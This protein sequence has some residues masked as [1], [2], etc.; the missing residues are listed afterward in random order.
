MILFSC[1]PRVSRHGMV[2]KKESYK[3]LYKKE[4]TKS[5][6]TEIFGSPSIKSTFSD[7]T[8]YYITHIN[9][10]IALFDIKRSD[11]LIIKIRFNNDQSIKYVKAFNKSN[12]TEIK[13]N[14]AK[15]S[16]A[17]SDITLLQELLGNV[18]KYSKD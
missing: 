6:V 9:K 14:K 18:G 16:T 8:W 15:T 1:A 17:T 10:E 13:I 7:N 3:S 2:V 4:L 5:E 11:Q 12:G